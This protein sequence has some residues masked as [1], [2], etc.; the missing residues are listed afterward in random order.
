MVDLTS[1]IEKG[2]ISGGSALDLGCGTGEYAG[3][4]SNHGFDVE[5]LDRSNEALGQASKQFPNVNFNHWDLNR[6]AN[7]PFRRNNYELVLDRLAFAFVKNKEQYLE[8]IRRK[9]NG[10]FILEVVSTVSNKPSLELTT[11]SENALNARFRIVKV[12]SVR[13]AGSAQRHTVYFLR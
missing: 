3:W 13:G 4:L 7:Y 6:L 9:L 12:I 5:A 10:T 1:W 2:G 8:T 11:S